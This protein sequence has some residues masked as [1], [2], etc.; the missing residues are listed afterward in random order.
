MTLYF[1]SFIVPLQTVKPSKEGENQTITNQTKPT[2]PC[3]RSLFLKRRGGS[4]RFR[5]C[6]FCLFSDEGCLFMAYSPFVIAGESFLFSDF[7]ILSER[8]VV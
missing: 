5:N 3:R 7:F 1:H 6:F 2:K 8:L 4:C